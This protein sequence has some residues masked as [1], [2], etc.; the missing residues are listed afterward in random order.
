MF[1]SVA[2]GE[3][4]FLSI[5]NHQEI[6][7]ALQ[8]FCEQKGIRAGV[9]G[10]IGAVSECTLRFFDPAT[11][12]YVDRTFREQMEIACLTGNVSCKDGA[13]YLHLHATFGR[14]DYTVIGGHLLTAWVSGACELYVDT[15]DCALGRR[16][17]PDIGLNMYAF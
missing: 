10:G 17:D 11:R 7:A 9:V 14:S 1:Q 12:Q 5:D 2:S 16:F 15:A 3:R 8:A 13:V 4:H 6:A